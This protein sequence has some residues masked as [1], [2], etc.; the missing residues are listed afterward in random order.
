MAI[1]NLLSKAIKKAGKEA[2]SEGAETALTKAT[3]KA[4]SKIGK[5]ILSEGAENALTKTATKG[6]TSAVGKKVAKDMASDLATD[7]TTK[8]VTKT[9]KNALTDAASGAVTKNLTKNLAEDVA[10]KATSTLDNLVTKSSKNIVSDIADTTAKKAGNLIDVVKPTTSAT[11][12]LTEA[13]KDT[14]SDIAIKKSKDIATELPVASKIASG[15]G[16]TAEDIATKIPVTEPVNTR[17]AAEV[18]EAPKATRAADTSGMDNVADNIASRTTA[19]S[20]L[21]DD[22]ANMKSRISATTGNAPRVDTTGTE[23]FNVRL[24]DGDTVDINLGAGA[25]GS[26]KQQRAARKLDDMTAK[27]MNANAKQYRKVVDKSGSIDGHYK[28]VAE[29]MRAENIDQANVAQKAQSALNLREEIKQNGLRYAENSGVTINLSGIDNSLGLSAA[30]KKKLAELGLS[31]DEMTGGASVVTPTQAE[32]IYK[33]LRDYAYNWSDSK[34]ALTKLAGNSCQKQADA[35]RSAIDKTMDNINV[36]Y[37]TSL[38]EAAASN[39]EDPAYLRKLSG[40]TDFKF[41]DLR[42]DQSDWIAINDLSGNKIKDEATLNI[43]GIDTGIEN[44]LT[45]AAD[46]IREKLYERQAS[47]ADNTIR[48][49]TP[50]AGTGTLG[51]LLAK[52]KGAG[53]IGAGVL[54][55]L[56]LG[57]GLGGGSE[58]GAGT[59]PMETGMM[60]TDATAEE[61]VSDPYSTLTIGGYTYNELEEGYIAA[62]NAGDSSAAKLIQNMMDMLDNKIE[63]Y[64]EAQKESSGSGTASK[65]ATAMS[66]LSNLMNNFEAQGPIGG[67]FTQFMNM[68]TGGGYNPAVSAYDTGSKGSLG[69]IIKALGDTGALSEGDQQRAL[70]LL[71]KTTDSQAAADAKYQQLMQILQNAGGK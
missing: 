2:I 16:D 27:S 11:K 49:N 46:K 38:I 14:A 15:V 44:P 9:A 64:A 63:R 34:D 69:M 35:V 7:I 4:A 55:G 66:V 59:M 57:G 41:S 37:K 58:A 8:A 22:I 17:A 48:F 26:S 56:M 67:R 13:A 43:L 31:L 21:A 29:R 40:K 42:K 36:D 33:T 1:T 50:N 18:L 65:Q 32:E 12:S 52:G 60:P 5:E 6:I 62:L 10:K 45:G 70:E 53:A 19:S 23:G 61:T 51:G 30:Q 25:A 54:G 28:T 39:G 20:T 3:T 47:G 24:K 71:P 68:L